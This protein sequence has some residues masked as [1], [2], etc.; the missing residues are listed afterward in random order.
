MLHST[1]VLTKVSMHKMHVKEVC[2]KILLPI[3]KGCKT[4][5]HFY[6]AILPVVEPISKLFLFAQTTP[7][8]ARNKVTFCFTLLTQN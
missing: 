7:G 5:M 6:I 2:L 1:T 4:N 3:L 8:A